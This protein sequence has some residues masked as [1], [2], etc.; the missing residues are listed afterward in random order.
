MVAPSWGSLFFILQNSRTLLCLT[1]RL[2][3]L[4]TTVWL[5]LNLMGPEDTYTYG[6][7]HL[8]HWH[9]SA[10]PKNSATHVYFQDCSKL[11]NYHRGNSS[12]ITIKTKETMQLTLY[13][14]YK[15]K[16]FS[17]EYYSVKEQYPYINVRIQEHK[18]ITQLSI[19]A[20]TEE[21]FKSRSWLQWN[22]WNNW[23]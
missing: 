4:Y 16:I 18:E 20:A 21:F 13:F 17:N 10:E 1:A 5:T 2:L 6:C 9:T 14:P 15:W 7:L 11:K 12:G 19:S 8:I 23:K 3:P 22:W